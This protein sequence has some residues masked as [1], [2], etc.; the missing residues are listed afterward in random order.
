MISRL[1]GGLD[2]VDREPAG[3]ASIDIAGDETVEA[4]LDEELPDSGNEGGSPSW[5]APAG[6]RSGSDMKTPGLKLEID[7][8][9]EEEEAGLTVTRVPVDDEFRDLS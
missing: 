7:P 1:A 3:L 2:P 8:E 5:E 9:D 6:T 4:G